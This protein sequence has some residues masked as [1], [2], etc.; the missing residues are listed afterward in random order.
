MTTGAELHSHIARRLGLAE[1]ATAPEGVE[2]RQPVRG[3]ADCGTTSERLVFMGNGGHYC[4][5]CA[6]GLAET[7]GYRP[8]GMRAGDIATLD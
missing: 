8:V 2:R 4:L 7:F 5:G 3:C 1:V 6:R